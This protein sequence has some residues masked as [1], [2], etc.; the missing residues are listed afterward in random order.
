MSNTSPGRN[1][2]RLFIGSS[3]EGLDIA[4]AV[5]SALYYDAE[6]IIWSQGVFGLSEGNLESLVREADKFDF[7]VFVLTADDLLSKRDRAGNAPR[8][9]V[10]FELGL[11]MGKLGRDR[12][13]F[14]YSQKD[15]LLLPSD[16][17]G[18]TAAAYLPPS[19]PRY[20]QAALS[21][22]TTPILSAIRTIGVR[23]A[24][25]K[26]SVEKEIDDLRNQVFEMR[27]TLSSYAANAQSF[28][29]PEGTSRRQK[30]VGVSINDLKFL[31][32]TWKGDPSNSTAWCTVSKGKARFLYCYMG[33][34]EPTGE[35]YDWQRRGDAVIGR[36]RWFEPPNISGYA[37]FEIAG[38]ECLRGGW[39][40]SEDVPQHLVKK[41]PHVP[42]IVPL[43]WIKITGA[44]PRWVRKFQVPRQRVNYKMR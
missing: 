25:D 44:V 39:W 24:S 30:K 8:D 3:V 19:E 37:W 6:P 29:P 41:L 36:F 43:E 1:R 31:E 20:L 40:M 35:Y 22:A 28:V 21:V 32:G 17:A 26:R 34:G 27:V 4:H 23:A 33:D 14:I 7:A 10:L 5:Q 12:T 18:V 16:L 2:P 42:G 38:A 15:W 13:F 9:N 11:F